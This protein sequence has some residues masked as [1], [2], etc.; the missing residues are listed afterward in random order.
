[1]T[2]RPR[3]TSHY[4]LRQADEIWKAGCFATAPRSYE[5][6]ALDRAALLCLAA[7]S[8]VAA[9]PK[10][11]SQQWHRLFGERWATTEDERGLRELV[12]ELGMDPRDEE[13]K[14][15]VKGAVARG[16]IRR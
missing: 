13:A 2:R 4:A 3:N 5:Q 15:G 10:E 8:V 11:L 9:W 16:G 12:R 7:R 14:E 6:R 1:M